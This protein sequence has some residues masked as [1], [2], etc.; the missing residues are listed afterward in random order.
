M[1]YR[2]SYNGCMII[3]GAEAGGYW[4]GEKLQTIVKLVL[5]HMLPVAAI[6]PKGTWPWFVPKRKNPR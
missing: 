5:L 2:M 6:Y 3:R 4:R 1:A